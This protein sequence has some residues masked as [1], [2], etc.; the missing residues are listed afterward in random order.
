MT[1][2]KEVKQMDES[3][4]RG[5]DNVGNDVDLMIDMIGK[6]SKQIKS[7]KADQYRATKVGPKTGKTYMTLAGKVNA[8]A[9]FLGITFDIEPKEVTIKKAAI[10]VSKVSTTAK[11]KKVSKK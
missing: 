4:R 7:L 9:E 10:K 3:I 5:F 8:I 1:L 2:R 6:N 11:A